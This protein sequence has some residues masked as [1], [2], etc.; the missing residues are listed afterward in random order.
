HPDMVALTASIATDIRLLG[1]DVLATKAHSRVL[2]AAG[3]LTKDDVGAIDEVLDE[4]TEEW[5]RGRVVPDPTDEDV[6]SLVERVLTARLGDVGKRIHAGRSRNDLVATDLRLWCRDAAAAMGD[7]LRALLDVIAGFGDAQSETLMPGYTHV[8]R[9]QPVSVGFHMLAHGFALLRD[10]HR[11]RHAYESADTSALGAGALAGNTLALDPTVGAEELR[12]SRIFD[13][14]MDAV[15]DRDFIADLL[16][17]CALC[18]VHLSR[19]AEELVLW[20][21][22]EFGF[23]RIADDWS[24]GSSMMQQKRNPDLAELIRG[25]AAGAVSDLNGL[26]VLLKGLP[27]AYDRDLQEDKEF[28]FRSFDRTS[29]AVR[30]MT[31]MLGAV[32][33]DKERLAAAA[34]GGSSWA[35]DL[36]EAL[37][38]RGIPFRSAHD[39]AGKLVA[40][41]E[42]RGMTLADATIEDLRAHH[43]AFE[44]GDLGFADPSRSLGARSSRGGTSPEE[45]RAQAARLRAAVTDL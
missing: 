26:L 8:Q 16:Y 11:F 40:S 24:T 14:A 32:R 9:G 13:N 3:L 27:L 10:L 45:V 2:L 15:S 6:H 39:V 12:F 37:V 43:E 25:R 22:S 19:L 5:K 7:D 21:S 44:P 29:G 18:S 42:Q 35:T 34:A 4:L 28:L 1:H 41:L 30:G 31:G 20:S 17:A 23:V 36:A 38:A 33:L